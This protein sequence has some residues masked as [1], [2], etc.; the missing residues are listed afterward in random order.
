MRRN[1]VTCTILTCSAAAV[2]VLAGCSVLSSDN[3][4]EYR[5]WNSTTCKMAVTV[6]DQSSGEQYSRTLQGH[7]ASDS[8]RELAVEFSDSDAEDIGLY[9]EAYNCSFGI[10]V[11]IKDLQLEQVAPGKYQIGVKSSDSYTYKNEVYIYA[12]RDVPPVSAYAGR[13]TTVCV[14]DTVELAGSRSSVAIHHYLNTDA[15]IKEYAWKCGDGTWETD[16][17]GDI[18]VPAPSTPQAWIC[19]LRVTDSRGKKDYDAVEVTVNECPPTA[20][21][22]YNSSAGI[23]DE[24]ELQGSG[25]DETE[26]VEYA[27]KCGER[28]WVAVSDGDTTVT[29]PG[30]AQSWTCSLRVTDD[31]GNVAYDTM[32]VLVEALAPTADARNDTTVGT[33]ERINLVGSNST[34]ES[35]IVEYAWKYAGGEWMVTGSGDT[36]VIASATD[37]IVR[38]S[39]RVTDSDSNVV[40]DY[41]VA[42]V[43]TPTLRDNDANEYGL[44]R[45]GKQVWTAENL[46]TTTYNDG[47]P[48]PHVP[49]SAGWATTSSGAYCYYDNTTDE[50]VRNKWGPL[51]NWYAVETEKLA[52]EGWH[53]PSYDEWCALEDYLTEN[54]YNYDGTTTSER[55][56]QSLAAQTDWESWTGNGA[57][58]NDPSENNSSGF[59]ALP[60][61]QRFT[62]CSFYR[63]GTDGYWW[64]TTERD[65]TRVFVIHLFHRSTS[66]DVDNTY[67][68]QG[69]SVRLLKD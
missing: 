5:F 45:I 8:E 15:Q 13:D 32:R 19:S 44:V 38:C 52:P 34:D 57:I 46:R 21:A 55:A 37:T 49:D 61:G 11:P 6:F 28:P 47:S 66:V 35:E 23:Y 39:L 31:D 17:D 7:D 22:G 12:A 16:V 56:A 62:N 41:I 26:I 36:S 51:Y 42:M 54:G 50:V 58:G 3:G 2:I 59:S 14:N 68:M 10:A 4:P 30:V 53:V 25:N 29:A 63:K 43:G 27:W 64:S 33:G 60:G 67:K 69:C 1:G 20:D 9:I 48:I 18:S 24:V 40:Y 65:S